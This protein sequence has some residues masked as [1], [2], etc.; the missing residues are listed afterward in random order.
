MKIE[1]EKAKKFKSEVSI[2]IEEINEREMADLDQ[3]LFD[4]VFGKNSVKSVTEMKNKLSEDFV[5]QFQ[6]Q[7][8][9]K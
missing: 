7:V 2:K 9:Q 8:D 3:D 6:N 5:K 4:K 1:L